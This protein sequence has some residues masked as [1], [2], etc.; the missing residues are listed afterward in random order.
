[1]LTFQNT[2]YIS[3]KSL[4][5][6]QEPKKIFKCEKVLRRVKTTNDPANLI[7]GLIKIEK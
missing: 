4:N 3:N 7:E 2:Q 1:M 6:P 5:N